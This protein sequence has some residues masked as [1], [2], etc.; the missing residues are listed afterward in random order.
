M[1]F[2]RDAVEDAKAEEKFQTPLYEEE[3]NE[4][5]RRVKVARE[6]RE[7]EDIEERNKELN[8]DTLVLMYNKFYN[9]TIGSVFIW[10][11]DTV[12]MSMVVYAVYE[13]ACLLN[14]RSD[15]SPIMYR[16]TAQS[17][18]SV[19]L[20][21][22]GVCALEAFRGK[23][24]ALFS[25][26][27][28]QTAKAC[29]GMIS[30]ISMVFTTTAWYALNSSEEWTVIFFPTSRSQNVALSIAM[31]VVQN[32][33]WLVS[34]VLAYMATPFGAGNSVFVEMP[35][36]SFLS[37]FYILVCEVG[38]SYFLVCGGSER[39]IATMAICNFA[40][41]TSFALHGLASFECFLNPP[42]D[43]EM[44]DWWVECR[45]TPSQ[46]QLFDP[47]TFLQGVLMITLLTSYT[48]SVSL[49][50]ELLAAAWVL[51]VFAMF[52]TIVKGFDVSWALRNIFD[53][54][55][56]MENDIVTLERQFQMKRG[57]ATALAW[58]IRDRGV[59][60]DEGVPVGTVVESGD[61]SDIENE[62]D[63]HADSDTRDLLREKASDYTR[64]NLRRRARTAAEI[65]PNIPVTLRRET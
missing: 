35:V 62:E 53:T 15:I 44:R 36:V 64:R 2:I 63:G 8:N 10:A 58:G 45:S 49:S 57:E 3:V 7:Q 30:C 11:F 32:A 61:E 19:C 41:L 39:F 26:L 40:L 6:L 5:V 9:Q 59:G 65:F 24:P 21:M 54:T 14:T 4:L 25:R 42:R 50:D 34:L 31:V 51:I 29:C 60:A 23:E 28:M 22:V 17:M 38:N 56:E 48:A 52:V 37:I 1:N 43:S 55:D 47:W 20:I 16:W 13:I 33:L 46:R 12:G 27:Y 18:L